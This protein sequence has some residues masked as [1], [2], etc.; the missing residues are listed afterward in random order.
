MWNSFYA[1]GPL[2]A[3]RLESFKEV[4][5]AHELDIIVLQEMCLGPKLSISR[6]A[7][8]HFWIGATEPQ[9]RVR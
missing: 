2:R 1:G 5:R 3:Q 6:V 8:V 7:Q 4:V 9:E